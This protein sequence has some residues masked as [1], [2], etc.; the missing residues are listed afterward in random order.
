MKEVREAVW[1]VDADLPLAAVHTLDHYYRKSMARTS[2]ILVMLSLAGLMALLLGAIG[3]YVVVA[4]ST[5]ERTHEIGIR[6]ALGAQR[7]A[8]LRLVMGQGMKLTL[9]GLTIGVPAAFGLSRFLSSLLYGVK[10]TD[11]LTFLGVTIMLVL[12]TLLACYIPAR[13]AMRVDPMVALKYE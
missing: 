5:S 8:T 13:R 9:L 3:L 10:P 12:V 6:M 7:G 11:P 2:F 1:S 4:Y